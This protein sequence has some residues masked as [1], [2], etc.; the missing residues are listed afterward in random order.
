MPNSYC[1]QSSVV[2]FAG[3]RLLTVVTHDGRPRKPAMR[4]AFFTLLVLSVLIK[5]F[6]S[7]AAAG[8]ASTQSPLAAPRIQKN[9]TDVGG[10]GLSANPAYPLRASANSRYL[11]DQNNVPFLL[12]GDSPQA[13]IGNLS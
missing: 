9:P 12:V 10:I 6:C 8:N 13:L 11:V 7:C 1:G 5:I 3:S 2:P 4:Q